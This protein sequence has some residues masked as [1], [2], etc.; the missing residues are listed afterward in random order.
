MYSQFPSTFVSLSSPLRLVL[1]FPSHPKFTSPTTTVPLAGEAA[2]SSPPPAATSLIRSDLH[3]AR[4]GRHPPPPPPK[5]ATR[6]SL[7]SLL[8]VTS[9]WA[10]RSILAWIGFSFGCWEPRLCLDGLFC[11]LGLSWSAPP[12][13]LCCEQI[14]PVP[15]PRWA[16]KFVW[17]LLI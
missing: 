16:L 4:S 9:N 11:E 1:R 17:L 2:T 12:F 10:R 13:H 6:N 15:F 5:R 14:R 8:L 7:S 3:P